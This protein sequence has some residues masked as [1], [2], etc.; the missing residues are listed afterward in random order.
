[1]HIEDAKH[2]ATQSTLGRLSK[3]AF[4]PSMKQVA[5]DSV[6]ACPGCRPKHQAPKGHLLALHKPRLQ[7]RVNQCLYLDLVGPLN[8]TKNGLKYIFTC[9]DGFSRY[10][11]AIAIKDKKADTIIACLRAIVNTWGIHEEI[12]C[13]HGRELDNQQMRQ[14]AA[15]LRVKQY[16][17]ISYEA[18]SNKVER[19]HRVQSTLLRSA[20]AEVND[21]EN[22][23]KYV[24]EVTRAYNT[25]VHSVIK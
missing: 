25:S 11:S 6:L 14:E 19:Y 20:L 4:W 23:Q 24:P 1:M 12:L 10:V 5:E 18:R 15:K 7:S 8:E 22:W 9:L 13:N 2:M 3:L 17:A 21:Y 16:F